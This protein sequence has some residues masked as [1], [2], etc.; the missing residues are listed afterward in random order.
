MKHLKCLPL[1]SV[2][3]LLGTAAA[4]HH[5]GCLVVKK[6]LGLKE[7]TC[8]VCYRR[9]PNAAETVGCGPLVGDKDKCVLY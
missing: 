3:C 5:A 8:D 7:P 4:H 1:F 6:L 9:K 2:L